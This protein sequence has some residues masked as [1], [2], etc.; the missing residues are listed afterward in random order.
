ML[1]LFLLI[2]R[3][4][5]ST[6]TDPLCP[7]TTLFRSSSLNAFVGLERPYQPSRC[8]AAW[9]KRARAVPVAQN[10]L[11]S[12]GK[13]VVCK[14]SRQ[15]IQLFPL[16]SRNVIPDMKQ[17]NPAGGGAFCLV[18]K[19]GSARV[20]LDHQIRINLHGIRHFVQRGDPNEADLGRAVGCD[21]TGRAHV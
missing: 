3:P 7:Y 8:E 20:E 6:R 15:N 19:T 18:R 4:P 11:F 21:K 16:Y 12:R 5:R 9:V 14:I 2:P 1:F 13:A 10:R 17:K